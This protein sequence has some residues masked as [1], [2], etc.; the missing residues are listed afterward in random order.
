KYLPAQQA[1]AM[2]FQ[3]LHALLLVTVG[4][5][6]PLMT[7]DCISRERREGTLGLLFLTNLKA[8]HV[9]L[10][11]S[12]AHGLR[13]ATLWFAVIPVM[14]LPLLMGGVDW[15][16]IALSSFYS[17]ELVVLS[18]LLGVIVSAVARGWI[19]AL[20]LTIL[21]TIGNA[22]LLLVG[23]MFAF[24]AGNELANGTS[25]ARLDLFAADTSGWAAFLSSTFSAQKLGFV[26]GLAVSMLCLVLLSI[27]VVLLV[28]KHLQ[29]NWQDKLKSRRQQRVEKKLYT[30]IFAL[31]FFRGW[32]RR[33]LERNPIGWLE[34]R[35]LSGRIAGWVWLAIMISLTSTA[36]SYG[37]L[38]EELLSV[39]MWA[40][41]A[42][43][44]YI[45]AAS[46]RRERETGALEL[47]LVTPLKEWTIIWGRLW[48]MWG[49]FLPAF[50][51]WAAA[52]VY[53]FSWMD[54]WRP[55]LLLS[56]SSSFIALPVIGLYFSLRSRVVVLAWLATLAIG[57][58]LPVLM[59]LAV[60]LGWKFVSAG[61]FGNLD[62]AHAPANLS[63]LT[64]ILQFF[65]AAFLL[66]RLH[67]LLVR[68]TF[69]LRTA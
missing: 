18:L 10:A 11:K 27:V 50:A 29:Q 45:A 48:G 5:L 22:W 64:S 69:S 19:T 17:L 12:F 8:H 38:M 36:V 57:F 1:G 25:A 3:F 56:F 55:T 4:V 37:R 43:L 66:W 59:V 30:P 33:S 21:L 15:R 68:R 52:M 49:I 41:L 60:R 46:F 16:Q 13:A 9:V 32:M 44:A 65:I 6:V 63:W 35:S 40:L 58:L 39:T 31:G 20:V 47:I 26:L 67:L 53:S 42:S 23:N 2:L 7:K 14:T 54:H 61:L 24:M 28:A 62:P 51:L 34:K